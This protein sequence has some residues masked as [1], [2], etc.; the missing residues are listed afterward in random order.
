MARQQDGFQE[1][2]GSDWAGD[3]GQR[4]PADRLDRA[5]QLRPPQAE[6]GRWNKFQWVGDQGHGGPLGWR[7][8]QDMPEG[9]VGLSGRRRNPGV[10][11][12]ATPRAA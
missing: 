2:D 9:E 12:W 11:H 5:A 7:R 8:A 4:N 1:W 3:N 10:Q 6:A